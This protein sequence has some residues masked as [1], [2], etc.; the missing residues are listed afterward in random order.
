MYFWLYNQST[1]PIVLSCLKTPASFLDF[2]PNCRSFASLSSST[3]GLPDNVISWK[4]FTLTYFEEGQL[5]SLLVIENSKKNKKKSG[6]SAV[7]LFQCRTIN[8]KVCCKQKRL[9]H[10]VAERGTHKESR[11][12]TKL[13]QHI[14]LHLILGSPST[15]PARL[16]TVTHHK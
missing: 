5:P 4:N 10:I 15:Q 1:C 8:I 11:N 7:L 6:N 12:T 9:C 16:H 2:E 14:L 13:R 3:V